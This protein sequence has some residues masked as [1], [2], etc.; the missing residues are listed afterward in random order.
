MSSKT[1][2]NMVAGADSA[3]P[4]EATIPVFKGKASYFTWEYEFLNYLLSCHDGVRATPTG[5]PRRSS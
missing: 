1:N 3:K 2:T 4:R 5:D